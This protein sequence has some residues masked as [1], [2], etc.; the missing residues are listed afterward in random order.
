MK[1]RDLFRVFCAL[2]AAAILPNATNES[3]FASD[4]W[5][6]GFKKLGHESGLHEM[7]FDNF[8]VGRN[9]E[10]AHAAC[11]LVGQS[12]GLPKRNPLYI[13]GPSGMGKSHLMMATAY[14]IQSRL[15][16]LN[17]EYLSASDFIGDLMN[18]VRR[19]SVADFRSRF[20]RAD[21]LLFDDIEMLGR[22]EMSQEEFV[23]IANLSRKEGK[24]VIVTSEL[25]P[26][27][28]RG[29][30]EKV[31]SRLEWGLIADILPPDYDTRFAIMSYKAQR[32]GMQVD[33]ET[34][35]YLAKVSHR[36]L[37]EM[38]GHLTKMKMYSQLMKEP[39]S[40]NLARRLFPT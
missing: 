21:L 15:P 17:V 25:M 8:V 33:R 32:W 20:A 3:M 28:I 12:P 23:R 16:K 7:R 27:Q 5:D 29:L 30:A 31:R 35:R 11:W 26:G 2:P 38:E 14:Q 39:I 19:N 36:S 18:S 37:R 6:K 40:I 34:L 9:N 24:Q 4:G 22:G 1:R 10:F 13:R